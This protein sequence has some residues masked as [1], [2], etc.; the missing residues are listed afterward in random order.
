VFAFGVLE[1]VIREPGPLL[2]QLPFGHVPVAFDLEIG[3][4]LLFPFWIAA[5]VTTKVSS[6]A[7]SR[8]RLQQKMALS[9]GV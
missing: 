4:N 9:Y 7:V 1:I 5:N 6:P 2:L 8:P 3:H